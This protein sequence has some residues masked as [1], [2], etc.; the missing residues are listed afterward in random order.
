MLAMPNAAALA[1]RRRIIAHIEA[2]AEKIASK[3]DRALARAYRVLADELT[4]EM[5]CG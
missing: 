4:A 1:E 3:G 2:R 5:H